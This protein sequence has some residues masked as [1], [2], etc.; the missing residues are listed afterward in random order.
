MVAD[1]SNRISSLTHCYMITFLASRV[2][3]PCLHREH[4]C[5]FPHVAMFSNE[6]V[7]TALK[8]E[9]TLIDRPH[10]Y[11]LGPNDCRLP[12]VPEQAPRVHQRLLERR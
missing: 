1:G 12:Q 7:D 10:F 6:S 11:F 8:L 5:M 9:L 2:V 4:A 3:M